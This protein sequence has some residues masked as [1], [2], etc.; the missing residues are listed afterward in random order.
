MPLAPGTR[1]NTY[2]ILG[3][4]GVG[5]MGEVY[6]G[7]DSRLGREVAI[8]VLPHA[9]AAEPRSNSIWA[10][11]VGSAGALAPSKPTLLT[12]LPTVRPAGFF[13][14]M[15][16]GRILFVDGPDVGSTPELRV[17]LN[18]SPELQRLVPAP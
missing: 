3:P 9:F 14:V 8:K 17:I 1:L 6:R 16:D 2:D 15:P 11:E 7:R 13:D 4:L 12:E 10:A 18:W 5:G